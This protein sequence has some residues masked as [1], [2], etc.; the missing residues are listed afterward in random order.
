MTTNILINNISGASPFNIYLCDPS[1]ITCIYID[2]IP[3]SSLPYEFVVPVIMGSQNSFSLKVVDS[4]NCVFYQ[5][6]TAVVISPTPT[7]TPTSTPTPTPTPATLV[8]ELFGCCD[9]TTQ[10]VL[11]NPTLAS[12]PGVYTAT[13][14]Q[15]YEVV[16]A[17]P[18]YGTPTVTITDIFNNYGDCSTWIIVFGSCP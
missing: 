4:N 7:I 10:Y 14:G 6:L 13:N 2:T 11:Y 15:P 8:L 5:N 18:S 17:T 9:L 12:L 1:N 16:N 3:S